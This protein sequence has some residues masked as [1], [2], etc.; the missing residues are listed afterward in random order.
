MRPL[1]ELDRTVESLACQG[2]CAWCC[3]AVAFPARVRRAHPEVH[4]AKSPVGV[5]VGTFRGT[6]ADVC[7]FLKDER[8]SIYAER[9]PICHLWGATERMPCPHGCKP[10]GPLLTDDEAHAYLKWHWRHGP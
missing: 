8:C 5:L 3:T 7:P 1:A 10:D 4:V 6:I 9:P 2:K